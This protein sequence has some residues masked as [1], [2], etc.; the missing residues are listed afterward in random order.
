MIGTNSHTAHSELGFARSV[1]HAWMR[2][3]STTWLGTIASGWDDAIVP[4]LAVAGMRHACARLS[5]ICSRGKEGAED[6]GKG[7]RPDP[8]KAS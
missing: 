7:C 5:Q 8:G 6:S 4:T 1:V 3:N 2:V